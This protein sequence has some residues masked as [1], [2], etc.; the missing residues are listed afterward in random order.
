MTSPFTMQGLVVE[1]FDKSQAGRS[2]DPNNILPL[3][4]P[5]E[6][7]Y[8]QLLE[9]SSN[10]PVFIDL[11]HTIIILYYKWYVKAINLAA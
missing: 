2:R 11:P 9:H 10:T 6:Y 4:I 7:L 3:L 5:F 8:W 1:S